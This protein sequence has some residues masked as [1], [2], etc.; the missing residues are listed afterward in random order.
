MFSLR[1]RTYLALCMSRRHRSSKIA[2]FRFPNDKRQAGLRGSETF[3]LDFRSETDRKSL[4]GSEPRNV[5][6]LQTLTDW[7]AV[8]CCYSCMQLVMTSRGLKGKK[9][10][11]LS[12]VE[13][14][15][16]FLSVSLSLSSRRYRWSCG[17]G[18]ERMMIKC[19]S[20]L[21][22]AAAVHILRYVSCLVDVEK[23]S[24]FDSF[25]YRNVSRL[26]C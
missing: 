8:C 5:L 24:W 18:K 14:T 9:S 25:S 12:F 23:E 6:P 13:S 16:H 20:L 7:L 4:A 10:D 19:N 15:C 11:R 3:I 17:R 26:S 1:P 21:S 22:N 2:G